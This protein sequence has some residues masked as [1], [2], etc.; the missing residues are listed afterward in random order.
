MAHH[1]DFIKITACCV[2]GLIGYNPQDFQNIRIFFKI[3][4]TPSTEKWST[5]NYT[6]S[7]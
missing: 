7:K 1:K 3:I 2:F 5:F 6:K 4:L